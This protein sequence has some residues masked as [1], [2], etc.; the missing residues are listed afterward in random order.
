ME[1]MELEYK[2]NCSN[3]SYSNVLFSSSNISVEVVDEQTNLVMTEP[4]S[5]YKSLLM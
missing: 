4:T 5:L 3:L 2:L 1:S